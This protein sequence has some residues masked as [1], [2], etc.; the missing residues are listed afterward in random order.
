MPDLDPE[1]TTPDQLDE[2]L[3]ALGQKIPQGGGAPLPT[4][5]PQVATPA[6][7]ADD[8][9]GDEDVDARKDAEAL[10]AMA[11]HVIAPLVRQAVEAGFKAGFEAAMKPTQLNLA[12]LRQEVGALAGTTESLK[13]LLTV[14]GTAML[15]VGER[16]KSITGNPTG[17]ANL[18]PLGQAT[19][20]TAP[21]PRLPKQN[22][23][24]LV[25][26][27]EG[28]VLKAVAAGAV[29]FDQGEFLKAG[30]CPPGF[31]QNLGVLF[32]NNRFGVEG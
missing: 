3:K 22:G 1:T 26:I 19:G 18:I 21:D 30:V 24:D 11:E 5:L 10:K 15:A 23:Y 4:P 31:V 20:G 16:L 28:E 7:P 6:D 29:T 27:P 8:E 32:P 9:E 17:G 13:S 25:A 2:A 12:A 14:Q